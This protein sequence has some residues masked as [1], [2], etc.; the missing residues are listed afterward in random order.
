MTSASRNSI[1][2]PSRVA[3]VGDVA[4]PPRSLFAMKNKATPIVGPSNAAAVDIK[5]D[6]TSMM[7]L[8]NVRRE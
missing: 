2:N 8:H 5:I 1:P 7:K 4:V 3:T 6:F